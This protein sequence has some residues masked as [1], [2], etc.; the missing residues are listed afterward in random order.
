MDAMER[1]CDRQRSRFD[2]SVKEVSTSEYDA[3][4]WGKEGRLCL[5]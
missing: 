3:E 5:S 2:G 4:I 1:E